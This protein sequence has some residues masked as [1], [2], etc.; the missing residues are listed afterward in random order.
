MLIYQNTF[1]DELV[2]GYNYPIEDQYYAE[3][4]IAI[5]ADGITRGPD[6]VTDISEYTFFELLQRYPR[7][8]GGELAAKEIIRTFRNSNNSSL[9]ERL[10]ECNRQ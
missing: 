4:N 7:P 10:I 6:G 8:S 1:E 5:I 9:K 3:D 2:K